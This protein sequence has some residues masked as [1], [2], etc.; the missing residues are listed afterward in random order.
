VPD[1]T[2]Y[3]LLST[4]AATAVLHTLIPDHWLPFVLIGRARGWSVA[5]VACTSGV[6]ALIHVGLSV[7][8]VALA[9]NAGLSTTA[10]VGETLERAGGLLLVVFGLGYAAWAWSKG[11]HFHPGGALLHRHERLPACAGEEGPR[12]PEHLHYHADQGLIR[13]GGPWT[14]IGL[15]V[16]VGL[17]PCVLVLPILLA[18]APRGGATLALV[19]VA[20][21]VPTILL[22]VGLPSIGV[23]LGWRVRLPWIARFAEPGSGLLIA[24]L[25]ALFW[26]LEH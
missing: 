21:G 1:A 14:G 9:L 11:G 3:A 26:V 13:G 12:H 7:G 16:I 23:A 24:L 5:T 4:A 25:G 2:L 22:M 19:A 20:Y 18:A 10:R 8:L 17:N 15:A 6:A